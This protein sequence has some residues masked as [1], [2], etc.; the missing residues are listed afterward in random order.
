M[1][2]T[3]G[4]TID[5]GQDRQPAD[6]G[7]NL[8]QKFEPLASNIRLLARQTGDVAARSRQAG[9]EASADRVARQCEDDRNDRCRLLCCDHTG[10]S[11]RGNDIDLEADELGRDLG[12]ALGASLRPA[13]LDRNGAALDPAEFAQTLHKSGG[14]LARARSRGRAQEPD[15]R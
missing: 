15:G 3:A 5:I 12:V 10:G 1:S 14:P 2:S 13:I 9:D 11:P 4:G 6:S 8:P 7:E